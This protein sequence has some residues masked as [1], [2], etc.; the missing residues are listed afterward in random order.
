VWSM[1]SSLPGSNTQ[2][3]MEL[4]ALYSRD[5]RIVGL[6][7]SLENKNTPGLMVCPWVS[8]GAQPV[9]C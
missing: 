8:L 7:R 3:S 4:Y 1:V 9:V 6:A 2:Y 5:E